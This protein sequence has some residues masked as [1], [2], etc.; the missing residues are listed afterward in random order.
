MRHS[1]GATVLD[2]AHGDDHTAA[3]VELL[4]VLGVD[5]EGHLGRGGSDGIDETA[6]DVEVAVGIH[7]VVVGGTGIDVAAADGEVL[8]RVDGVVV[9]V[10]VDLAANNIEV[11]FALHT[12]TVGAAGGHLDAAAA[13]HKAA[14]VGVA[15]AALGLHAG[16]DALGRRVVVAR[17]VVGVARVVGVLG[18]AVV[19]VEATA[20]GD[21]NGAVGEGHH[22]VAFHTL[23]ARAGGREVERAA[24]DVHIAVAAEAA[25]RLGLQV[26]AVPLAVAT[27]ANGNGAA[28]D[29][30]VALALDAF[31]CGGGTGDI[32]GAAADVDVAAVLILMVGSLAGREG[33]LQVALYA[34]VAR[35]A[36]VDGAALHQEVLVARDAVAHGRGDVEGGV[37]QGDVLAGLDT[38]LHVARDVEGAL[39]LELGVPFDVEAAFLRAAGGIDEGVGGAG[40]DLDVDALAVLYVHGGAAIDGRGVGQREAVELDG[41]LVGARHIELAIGRGAAERIGDLGGQVAALG[42]ADVCSALRDGKVLAGDAVGGDGGRRAIIHHADALRLQN[43]CRQ[44]E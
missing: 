4:L 28:A 19:V 8:R 44:K 38:V 12:L 26:V 17:D 14:A 41:S 20:G 22:A 5:V 23:A 24:R 36:D 18:G 42:D 39:L 37:L 9:G 29:V 32:D 25:G 13:D 7:T 30:H 1:D 27:G 34:V 16:F 6:V 10:D 11:V 15:V 40:N 35:A 31:G 3:D 33:V 43:T 2:A 21:S